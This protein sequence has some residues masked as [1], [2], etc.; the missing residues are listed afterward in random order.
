MKTHTCFGAGRERQ[1]RGEA[2]QEFH[3]NDRVDANFS[4][5]MHGSQR[6][7]RESERT[8][9]RDRYH[10]LLGNDVH[11]VENE[12]IVFEYDEVNIFTSDHVERTTNCRL[13]E[14]GS[15]LYRAL[16]E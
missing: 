12:A 3:V 4:D 15:A 5:S 14:N 7:K 16:D 10:I 11:C 2:C 1:H 8:V 9:R 6:T 13:S